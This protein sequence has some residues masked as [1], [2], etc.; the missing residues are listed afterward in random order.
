M[1]VYFNELNDKYQ[2]SERLLQAIIKK[3]N[4]NSKILALDC[5]NTIHFFPE[6]LIIS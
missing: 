3:R 6:F 1:D 4:L 5:C 2:G